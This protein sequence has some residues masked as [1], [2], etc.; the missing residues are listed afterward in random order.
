MPKE[1]T[2]SSSFSNKEKI[3]V[4][5]SPDSLGDLSLQDLSR[6]LAD[7]R[8]S[9]RCYDM[10]KADERLGQELERRKLNGNHRARKQLARKSHSVLVK[11]CA[12][13]EQY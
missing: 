8:R 9:L 1:V 4:P 11:T 7:A 2:V 6:K 13:A 12:A 3:F 5:S 10:S